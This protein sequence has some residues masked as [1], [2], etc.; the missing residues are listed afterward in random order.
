MDTK[1]PRRRVANKARYQKNQAT[2]KKAR[3]HRQVRSTSRDTRSYVRS[4]IAKFPNTFYHNQPYRKLVIILNDDK[5][6]DR[7]LLQVHDI[8]KGNLYLALPIMNMKD[9][10]TDA[11]RNSDGWVKAIK[12][13]ARAHYGVE[14]SF[15][16]DVGDYIL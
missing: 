15:A 10:H 5:K 12:S 11:P 6:T 14:P 1:K 4:Q 13:Y 9:L 3:E 7:V 16:H 2:K 8:G